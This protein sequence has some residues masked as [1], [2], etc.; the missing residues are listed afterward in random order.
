MQ[1]HGDHPTL[2]DKLGR[3]SLINEMAQQIVNCDSPQTF[4]LHGDW[5]GW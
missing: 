5:G 4:G 1:R 3:S 2:Y